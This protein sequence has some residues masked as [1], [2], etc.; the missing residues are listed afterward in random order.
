MDNNAQYGCVI[1]MEV[2]TG[3]IKAV[4]NLGKAADDTYKEDYNY[5]F[6]DQGR[7]EPGSTFKLASM[8]AL[9]EA[10]PQS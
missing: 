10:R 5:A 8:M 4:A 7:T 2:A 1:L 3:E 6:A 9:F